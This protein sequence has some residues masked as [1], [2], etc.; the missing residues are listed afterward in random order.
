M[1]WGNAI[2][3][4]VVSHV[5]GTI[6]SMTMELHL[7]GDFKTTE[8]KI[9]WLAASSEA[10]Q[11]VEVT[12]HDYDYLL[13]KPKLEE[14]DVLADVLTP[15][16][17]FKT[18]AF[19]DA[20]TRQL[21]VGDMFQFERKGYFICDSVNPDGSIEAIR[22]PADGKSIRHK[23]APT[24]ERKSRKMVKASKLA[25]DVTKA[26]EAVVQSAQGMIASTVQAVSGLALQAKDA[27]L[28]SSQTGG[29][30]KAIEVDAGKMYPVAPIDSQEAV[31]PG[32]TNMY[33]VKPFY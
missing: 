13:T 33:E 16:T 29:A 5:D 27:L 8:K 7:E 28:G 17:E 6:Q 14:D 24:A 11:L 20:N 26:S 10:H 15:V 12:F 3:R 23:A 19:A 32:R 22:I 30:S 25:E 21:K 1:D 4:D 31:N 9:S 18:S 2:V